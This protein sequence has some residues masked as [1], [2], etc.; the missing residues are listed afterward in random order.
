M[1]YSTFV[2]A[3]SSENPDNLLKKTGCCMKVCK[4]MSMVFSIFAGVVVIMAVGY[5]V[6]VV[7]GVENCH[8]KPEGRHSNIPSFGTMDQI[9]PCS[10]IGLIELIVAAVFGVMSVIT[11]FAICKA[12]IEIK[13]SVEHHD[14]STNIFKFMFSDENPN[15][16]LRKTYPDQIQALICC[17]E[18]GEQANTYFVYLARAI[19]A[20]LLFALLV[21]FILVL[22]KVGFV[23][24]FLSDF[25]DSMFEKCFKNSSTLDPECFM[26]GMVVFICIIVVCLIIRAA[27]EIFRRCY[28]D[29]SKSI[30]SPEK[31]G[32]LKAAAS[33]INDPS[34]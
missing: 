13:K 18:Y 15:N 10:L 4:I 28:S 22:G 26:P 9:I 12:C 32:S 25:E 17:F 7:S 8:N 19:A 29:I 24:S 3:F 20:I 30:K 21:V 11:G 16:L 6:A 31:I 23:F 27:V 14:G 1:N 2:F 34:L 5:G 33:S